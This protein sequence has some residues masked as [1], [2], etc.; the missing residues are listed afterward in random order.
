MLEELD[1]WARLGVEGHFEAR[2]PWCSYHELV[3]DAGARL[4]GA[5]PR[6]S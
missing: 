2:H 4:V 6:E 1:D 3:R 5:L